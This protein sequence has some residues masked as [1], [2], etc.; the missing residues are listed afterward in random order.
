MDLA[1]VR[2]NLIKLTSHVELVECLHLRDLARHSDFDRGCNAVAQWLMWEQGHV[3]VIILSD[4][5]I[6]PGER[7]VLLV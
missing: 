5:L 2:G 7:R 1:A 6:L 3:K 4:G